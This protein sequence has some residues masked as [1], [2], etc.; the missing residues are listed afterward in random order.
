MINESC[1]NNHNEMEKSYLTKI[2]SCLAELIIIIL[3]KYCTYL[4]SIL[5]NLAID[6]FVLKNMFF[7]LSFF[8]TLI[9]SSLY[10]I[11]TAL[12]EIKKKR[13]ISGNKKNFYFF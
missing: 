13:F 7:S 9:Y 2:A 5:K 10:V 6:K 3:D 12:P 8:Y 1:L 4:K 11:D